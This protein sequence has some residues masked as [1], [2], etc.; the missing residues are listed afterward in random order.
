MNL[1]LLPKQV[2]KHILFFDDPQPNIIM[3]HSEFYRLICSSRYLTTSGLLVLLNIDVSSHSI[4]FNK[5][6]LYFSEERE[7]NSRAIQDLIELEEMVLSSFHAVGKQG[8]PKLRRQ[9]SNGFIRIY[10]EDKVIRS[11]ITALSL[12]I[13]GVWCTNQEYG[14]TF[15]F[16]LLNL[17]DP[18]C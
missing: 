17:N 15:K 3:S 11:G 8:V 10:S 7:F 16:V 2:A 6:R 12:K 14:I 13:S 18:K 4:Y 9:L 5:H 1:L